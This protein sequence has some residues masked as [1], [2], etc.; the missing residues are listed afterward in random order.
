[1]SMWQITEYALVVSI[2]SLLLLIMKRLFHDKLDARWHYYIWLVLVVRMVAPLKWEWLKSPISL[3]E[4]IPVNYWVGM[5]ELYFEQKGWTDVMNSLIPWYLAGVSV[6]GLYYLIVAVYVRVRS[7][8]FKNAPQFVYEQVAQIAERYGLKSCRRI[9]IGAKNGSAYVCGLFWPVLVLPDEEVQEQVILHELL[10]KKHGDV[11]INYLL[12]VIRA[13]NWYNPLLWYVTSVILNDSEALCDQRVLEWMGKYHDAEGSE[14]R[15]SSVR[16]DEQI[17]GNLLLQMAQQK[18]RIG[19]RMG[20]TN[21]ANSYTNMKT[22][23][24]RIA[25]FRKVPSGLGFAALCITIILSIS[26]ISYCQEKKIVSDNVDTKADLNRVLLRARLY[27]ARTP[28]EALYLYL[29]AL[30]G[31]NPVY[32]MAVIPQEEIAAYENWVFEAFENDQFVRYHEGPVVEDDWINSNVEIAENPWFTQSGFYMEGCRIYNLY[33]EDVRAKADILL[34]M[35]SDSGKGQVL[36]KVE[37]LLEDGWKVKRLSEMVMEAD[38]AL[39]GRAEEQIRPLIQA[40]GERG[41]WKVVVEGRNEGDFASL[42]WQPTFVITSGMPKEEEYRTQFDMQYKRTDAYVTYLG[43]EQSEVKEMSVA[44]KRYT[45]EEYAQ[46]SIS[47][48]RPEEYTLEEVIEKE[49]GVS[50]KSRQELMKESGQEAILKE[51]AEP[52]DVGDIISGGSFTSSSGISYRKL[53]EGT[54]TK[55]ECWRILGTGSGYDEWT[56]REE[57][58]FAAWIFIDGKCVEV[59]RR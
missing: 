5:C 3:F 49:L 6:F 59:I 43:E 41:D 55:G 34:D 42:F 51:A 56:G 32:L 22:R 44:F 52:G 7:L 25:D 2:V 14:E 19:A 15:G 48:K 31:E 45:E 18:R 16:T 12:H 58:H 1:M 29:R 11:L 57:I 13:L 38:A 47:G 33:K 8:C 26:G 30:K 40:I 46:L 27:E 54:I 9:K 23:I 53:E 21:M 17:Y 20:T 10:H 28:E 35:H 39:S 24:R 36:W 4:A 50:V 37:L